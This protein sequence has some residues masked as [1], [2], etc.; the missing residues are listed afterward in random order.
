MV[1]TNDRDVGE[2]VI[3]GGAVAGAGA[4]PVT[5]AVRGK[6]RASC[7]VEGYIGLQR[8]V[9]RRVRRHAGLRLAADNHRRTTW[10]S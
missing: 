3:R 6:T 10:P 5:K 2:G 9:E 4:W 8:C 1:R 7:Q